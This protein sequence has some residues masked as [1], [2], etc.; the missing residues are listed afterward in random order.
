MLETYDNNEIVQQEIRELATE[1]TRFQAHVKATY[2]YT[3]PVKGDDVTLADIE[4]IL[5][6]V[7]SKGE[8]VFFDLS[9]YKANMFLCTIYRDQ[10]YYRIA[11][12]V[13]GIEKVGFASSSAELADILTGGSLPVAHYSVEWDGIEN[14]CKRLNDAAGISTTTTHFGHFGSV[15]SDYDNPFDSIYPWSE[16]KLC[17]ID[18]DEYMA[19]GAG[20]KITD[21]VKAWEGDDDFSY[22]DDNGVWV[23]TPAFYGRTF[24]NGDKRYF[25]VTTEA[26]AGNIFYPEMI[27]GRWHGVETN[28]TIGGS[29]KA[30]LLPKPGIS[31][32]GKA[33]STYHTEAK[34]YKASLTDIYTLD[35]SALLMVVEYANL[36][37][38]AAVGNGASDVYLQSGIHPKA[39]VTEDDEI[40]INGL[41]AAQLAMVIPGAIVDLG[42]SDGAA[43]VRTVV[44]EVT[45]SGSDTTI[46][47]ADPVTV[48]T[49]MF[50]SIHGL[51]NKADSDIG[52]KSGYI[53]T[54]GKCSAYYRGEVLWGNKFQ[55]ILGAYRQ[56][57]TA[58]V[59]VC[60]R[61][62]DPDDF[63][64]LDTTKHV[65]TDIVLP[66]SGYIAALGMCEGLSIPPFATATGSGAGSTKPV[67][68][69]YY[70]PAA[71]TAN[72]VL[73]AGGSA[74]NGASDGLF[75]GYWNAAASTS[76]WN[77]GARPHL[78]N[79]S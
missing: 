42:A 75:Y 66:A 62:E 61:S 51:I 65:N 25:D 24:I 70:T 27:T 50:V 38:Q 26:T 31:A 34:N 69:Y 30:C 71:N 56:K 22:T 39:A 1:Q 17:N 77:F 23:Y 55:Y 7:N 36:N 41:S 28:L 12:M 21:C 3:I 18:I 76:N 63:D 46:T 43:T 37:S 57:D 52:S 54:N 10:D 67:G 2:I 64:A 32:S 68:D 8:H 45:T 13:T 19:L 44:E 47:L 5:N 6:K 79:P 15:D 73:I 78:K 20:D 40:V 14:T 58:K 74:I 72:T 9:S 59:W 11:D 33:M 16:R 53:G 49:D 35:A 29:S 48:T 60:P 4:K